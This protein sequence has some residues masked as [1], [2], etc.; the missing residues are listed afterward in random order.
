MNDNI[1][2][3]QHPSR[4]SGLFRALALTAVVA[5]GTVALYATSSPSALAASVMASPVGQG[6]LSM[7]GGDHAA[8][9][10]HFLEVLTDAGANEA[11][12]QRIE[13]IV[14]DAMT[15]QHADM[16]RYHDTAHR[17]KDVLAAPGIDLTAVNAIRAE[18]DQLALGTSR[19]ITDTALAISQVLTAPQRQKL[20][21][22]I[23]EMIASRM[24]HHQGHH[25][26]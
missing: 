6:F 24:G 5:A 14:S 22:H 10:A 19:R 26:D 21:A 15:T 3:R 4:R 1:E 23:D 18:Q 25:Q 7:H 20:G 17:L 12:K 13:A 8:M 11:Q 16:Q 2:I 9:H